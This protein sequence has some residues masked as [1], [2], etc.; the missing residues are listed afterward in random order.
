MYKYVKELERNSLIK[1]SYLLGV[2]SESWAVYTIYL[3]IL[4]YTM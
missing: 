1:S 4:I 2:E 3:N